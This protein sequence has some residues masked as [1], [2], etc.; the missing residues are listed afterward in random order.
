MDACHLELVGV[1][2]SLAIH[3]QGTAIFLLTIEDVG[4]VI[5]RIHN[6]LYSFGEFNLLSASQLQM[7]S[8]NSL[9][10]SV[11]DPHLCLGESLL[12]PENNSSA[13][14]LGGINKALKI[15]LVMDEGLYSLVMEPLS[16]DDPRFGMLPIY[17]VTPPG[18]FVPIS[19]RAMVTVAEGERNSETLTWT[20]HV[21]SE[22]PKIGRILVG[23]ILAMNTSQSTQ[24]FNAELTGFCDSFLAPAGTPPARKQY[25]ISNVSHMSDLSVRFLGIGTD[26]LIHTVGISNGLEHPPSKKHVRVPPLNFPQG[27]M[28][29]SKTP[30]V[31]KKLVGHKHES[32]IAEALY[33]DT[34]FSGDVKFPMGQAFVDR[35]SRFGYIHPLR[36][37]RDVGDA[38]VSFVC[39]HYTPLVLISDNI[40]ENVYGSLNDECRARSV[41][42]LFTCPYHPQQNFA[43]GYLGRITTMASFGMVHSGAPLFM[44]IWATF[45]AVF[46]NNISASYYSGHSVWAT[47]YELLHQE[48]FPDASIVVPFGCAAL[49]MLEDKDLGKFKSRCAL[50]IFVHY[51]DNHPLYTYAFYSP[52]TK[53]VLFRQDCIFLTNVFP[54]RSARLAAG[55]DP[56]GD[57]IASFRAPRLMRDGSN[58]LHSFADWKENEDLPPYDDHVLGH[59][60]TRPLDS[61]ILGIQDQER[62]APSRYPAHPSFGL[63]SVV[64]VIPPPGFSG[65]FS[66]R[67][68]P[69]TELAS[70]AGV[71]P[72]GTSGV[73][74]DS[75]IS[76]T[77]MGQNLQSPLRP[78]GDERDSNLPSGAPLGDLPVPSA[79]SRGSAF[80]IH[81]VFPGTDRPRQEY[82]VYEHMAVRVL[83]NRIAITL[84]GLRP[85]NIRI[86]VDNQCLLH[87][88]TISDRFYPPHDLTSPTVYLVSG[89]TAVIRTLDLSSPYR[90]FLD[91]PLLLPVSVPSK[92]DPDPTLLD[93]GDGDRMNRGDPKDDPFHPETRLENLVKATDKFEAALALQPEA[94]RR[95]TKEE[96]EQSENPQAQSAPRMG[97]SPLL[98][99]SMEIRESSTPFCMPVVTASIAKLRKEIQEI[100]DRLRRDP[101][102]NRKRGI[103][104]VSISTL[105]FE[106]Q[107]AEDQI[108]VLDAS[109][110]SSS[111]EC[112]I[113][114]RRIADRR[115]RIGDLCRQILNGVRNPLSAAAID[116]LHREIS[117]RTFPSS[118][119]GTDSDEIIMILETL[120]YEKQDQLADLQRQILAQWDNR[121]VPD[122][123]NAPNSSFG[124][125]DR[126]PDDSVDG[127]QDI[128]DYTHSSSDEAFPQVSPS[129]NGSSPS[130]VNHRSSKNGESK[131]GEQDNFV[132]MKD[133]FVV[134]DYFFSPRDAI[135]I[136]S[137][138][139][140]LVQLQFANGLD[141]DDPL[142][143][144]ENRNFRVYRNQTVPNFHMEIAR[145]VGVFPWCV[146]ILIG[147]KV[148]QH[149]GFIS[150]GEVFD[151]QYVL[152][153]RSPTLTVGCVVSVVFLS[154]DGRAI[155][156]DKLGYS[157]GFPPY[158]PPG[159]LTHS[160]LALG[161]KVADELVLSDEDVPHDTGKLPPLERRR[162]LRIFN[163]QARFERR[164]FVGREKA[165][166]DLSRSAPP[167]VSTEL[168][169]SDWY[170]QEFEASQVNLQRLLETYDLEYRERLAIFRASFTTE[171]KADV[172]VDQI[173]Q[174][175]T[176]AGALLRQSR[177]EDLW[178]QLFRHKQRMVSGK[179]GIS[180]ADDEHNET[181]PEA[182]PTHR[183]P[184][185][186]TKK[187][188]KLSQV[189]SG[190]PK[191]IPVHQRWYYEPVVPLPT[192]DNG[193]PGER[194]DSMCED[195]E[196][197]K[198][199]R[200]LKNGELPP[201]LRRTKRNVQ[202]QKRLVLSTKCIRRILNF[203][204]SIFKYGVL[205]PK[206]DKEADASPEAK[207][208]SSGKELEWL[209]LRVQGTFE[210]N[211]DWSRL[212]KKYPTY[213]KK[214]IGHVFFVYDFKHSG[215]HR[216]RLVFDG[217]KQNPETYTETYAPTVRS[218][219][220]RLFHV[221]GVEESYLI[222]QYDVPQAFLKSPIDCVLFV[223]PPQGFSEYQGQLLR[224]RLSLYGAKQSAALWNNL[225]DLFLKRLGFMPSPMDP[226]FY[227]RSDAL[228]ILFC[229]DLRVAASASVLKVIHDALFAE[230]AITTSDGTRFLGMDTMY[231]V[232]KG[233]LKIHMETYINMTKERFFNFDTSRGIPYREIVGCLLWVCLCVM[234]PELL[235]VK[236]LARRSNDYTLKDFKEALKVLDRMYE[237]RTHGIIIMRGG[238]GSELTPSFSRNE[239][240]PIF[241]VPGND[242]AGGVPVLGAGA[243][244]DNT[245]AIAT[246]NELR[247]H[248][249]YKVRDEI[250]DVDI[251]PVVLPPNTRY[252]LTIYADASFAVGDLM[253]SVSGY[254]IYLNGTPLLWGSLKQTIIVDSSCSAEFVAASVACKQAIYA[255][256]LIGFLGFSCVRPYTMYTDSTA[257]L[258]IATN[259]SR[260]GNV[261]H[262]QIR[263]HLIRCFV[264]LGN[265]H[266]LYCV[267]EEMVAD[268]LTKIVSG[269]QDL[270]LSVRFYSLCPSV[271][272]IVVNHF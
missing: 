143:C 33:S 245:G 241:A 46:V 48:P 29:R 201:V 133:D 248:S 239:T 247:E 66:N 95:W 158:F 69:S 96:K 198:R 213:L 136:A 83:Y 146:R 30:R 19:Q 225:I 139:G 209:R 55:L 252:V 161:E 131:N 81:L 199:D 207:R 231:D 244:C 111:N 98:E 181:M 121:R 144:M 50:L 134:Q 82:R 154:S 224:L 263:Y 62:P 36:S 172:T 5:L 54:M 200:V 64:P 142:K 193:F 254:I 132:L 53:R 206:N 145:L 22:P 109:P 32:G 58:P 266:M 210:R 271:H 130:H 228:V 8:G 39:K 4:E 11:E 15:P 196:E 223:Y 20:T 240:T 187:S 47:P 237:R 75:E 116:D 261:R 61:E 222:A 177:T 110:G 63:S 34:F 168:E 118:E 190:K 166:W 108:A 184:T 218:E 14:D 28:K 135:F 208:W 17:D 80:T 38:F 115:R 170:D 165:I 127:Q 137:E 92:P 191:R 155:P 179:L 140:F 16:P 249:I 226:C 202:K 203:K 215:E 235:R 204:E 260:L 35:T 243:T 100:E 26:R 105:R 91:E 147:H 268:L 232:E 269:A 212:Q 56:D 227:K 99:P 44:W 255:E 192:A 164:L 70:M 74:S 73:A 59:K 120:L 267:T 229:D 112:E 1:S 51:A 129:G 114:H 40:S 234:G 233:Y 18:P 138:E 106:I 67:G 119:S 31:N 175:T 78:D 125:R 188:T 107:E 157:I 27:N 141:P 77:L 265:I 41:K 71:P 37:R 159:G 148:L 149:R 90:M 259:P 65:M 25:D 21:L 101:F 89:S 272:H 122:D 88:G 124:P 251:S 156:T 52:K 43:E 12:G 103:C 93:A 3:G 180:N 123:L 216:V 23:R 102:P 6:C 117:T 160:Y 169:L 256:N 72:P 151:S 24:D 128:V 270:R 183:S 153:G 87:N 9:D 10:L 57:P 150:S 211:W 42:Q 13:D 45:T 60:M 253:Q 126:D 219:S 171:S 178:K 262:V 152:V 189:P 246:M 194:D 79:G 185:D 173:F 174:A 186:G 7:V 84:L 85:R 220:V 217:S 182:L 76:G 162:R 68:I 236:D 214:D 242:V 238:A 176:D 2:G 94:A 167:L 205:V 250:A 264:T 49:V 113:L 195:L 257:C 197:G 163:G 86:Y 221:Y 104:H 258:H 230:F 97:G